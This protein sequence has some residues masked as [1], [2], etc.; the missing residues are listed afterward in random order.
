MFVPFR[1]ISFG[2]GGPEPVRLSLLRS[3]I[4][5]RIKTLRT[6]I[7]VSSTLVTTRVKMTP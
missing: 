6:T 5:V 4:E 3:G 7:C 1:E 2:M